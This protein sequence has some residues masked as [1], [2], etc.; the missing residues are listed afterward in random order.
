MATSGY[1]YV[2]I[3]NRR[4]VERDER[5]ALLHR[6]VAE[7]DTDRSIEDRLRI[8]SPLRQ[9]WRC[10]GA[11]LALRPPAGHRHRPQ[12]PVSDGRPR[13]STRDTRDTRDTAT[14]ASSNRTTG[15]THATPGRSPG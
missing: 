2:A 14:A 12:A 13:S 11:R 9:G 4:E 8:L 1:F 5:A 15:V 3:D 7:A 6:A 10:F